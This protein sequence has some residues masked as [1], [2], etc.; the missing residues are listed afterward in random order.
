MEEIIDYLCKKHNMSKAAMR[1]VLESPF[2]F[3]AGEIRTEQCNNI[4]VIGLGKFVVKTRYKEPENL[5]KFLDK[6]GTKNKRN[7]GRVEKPDV[8]ESR[9][10]EVS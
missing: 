9:D 4:N 3:I 6:Y 1:A 5:K 2:R 7:S 10:R 8:G